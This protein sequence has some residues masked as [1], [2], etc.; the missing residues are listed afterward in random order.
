MK[1]KVIWNLYCFGYIGKNRETFEKKF[2]KHF[3]LVE[4]LH[5]E[6]KNF[7]KIYL[8]Y[9]NDAFVWID[10]ANLYPSSFA[11]R[12]TRVKGDNK[13]GFS[14]NETGGFFDQCSLSLLSTKVA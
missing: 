12:Y 8:E 10:G 14:E 2:K 5:N 6:T 3:N 9:K 4:D 7:I 11:N 1:N 13:Y